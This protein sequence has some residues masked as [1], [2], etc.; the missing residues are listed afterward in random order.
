[1]FTQ[2]GFLVSLC[3]YYLLMKKP[4]D[5]GYN[6]YTSRNAAPNHT[7]GS[8]YLSRLFDPSSRPQFSETHLVVVQRALHFFMLTVFLWEAATL[9]SLGRRHAM[10]VQF[11]LTMLSLL[12]IS[13]ATL[14]GGYAPCDN[15]WR[16]IA[17]GSMTSFLIF[18]LFIVRFD[19]IGFYFV[20][21][22]EVIK[23]MLKVSLMLFFFV[24]GMS[25]PLDVMMP[26]DGFKQGQPSIISTL[27]M[28]LGEMQFRDNFIK[29]NNSPFTYDLYVLFI[30]CCIFLNLALMNLM[31]GAAVGDISKVEKRAYITRLRTQ[32][33]FLLESEAAVLSGI[34]GWFHVEK[35]VIRPNKKP[36]TFW[37]AIYHRFIYPEQIEFIKKTEEQNQ[38]AER[39]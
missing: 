32:V 25:I 34:R 36:K 23:T 20:M 4:H 30:V 2:V 13:A 39:T 18:S 19:Q 6:C 37:Q 24:L 17:A 9:W 26:Q 38:T 12:L 27:A 31:I 3:L 21:Y 15:E 22:F 5:D 7:N 10:S 29:G 35:L 33:N 8:V 11:V 28:T 14:P 1:M 16:A